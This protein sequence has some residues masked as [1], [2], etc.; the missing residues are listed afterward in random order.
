MCFKGAVSFCP[1]RAIVD[2]ALIAT[3]LL[4][5][6]KC[7]KRGVSGDVALKLDVSKAYDRVG[8]ICKLS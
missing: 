6:M 8:I 4:C 5:Y 1:G 3:E 2:N 7:K